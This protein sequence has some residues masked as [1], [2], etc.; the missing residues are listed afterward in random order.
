MRSK[1]R[2]LS[3]WEGQRDFVEDTTISADLPLII[4]YFWAISFEVIFSGVSQKGMMLWSRPIQVWSHGFPQSQFKQQHIGRRH[5]LLL[6][7]THSQFSVLKKPPKSISNDKRFGLCSK[8]VCR[9]SNSCLKLFLRK[10]G[11]FRKNGHTRHQHAVR[12]SP[13]RVIRKVFT[14]RWSDISVTDEP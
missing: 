13:C 5:I 7:P 11:R 2:C 6:F 3:F 4:S 12:V 10:N 8:S 1:Q 14:A 9:L